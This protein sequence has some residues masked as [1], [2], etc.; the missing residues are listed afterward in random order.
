MILCALLD[1]V[2]DEI[3][4]SNSMYC[5]YLL[6]LST[7]TPRRKSSP[8]WYPMMSSI[9][10]QMGLLPGYDGIPATQSSPEGDMAQARTV[11]ISGLFGFSGDTTSRDW[12]SM[13][14]GGQVTGTESSFSFEKAHNRIRSDLLAERILEWA[15][16]TLQKQLTSSFSLFHDQITLVPREIPWFRVVCR[17]LPPVGEDISLNRLVKRPCSGQGCKVCNGCS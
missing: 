10:C 3:A 13:S 7:S 14:A 11:L 17:Q 2:N 6:G 9:C 4:S 8:Q 16:S 5:T 1:L 15:S 12:W